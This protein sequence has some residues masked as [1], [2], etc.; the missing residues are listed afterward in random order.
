L[1]DP[2]FVYECDQ[3]RERITAPRPIFDNSLC[4]RPAPDGGRCLGHLQLV[5][6]DASKEDAPTD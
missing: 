4:P 5:D 6:P 3:C 1:P 2:G